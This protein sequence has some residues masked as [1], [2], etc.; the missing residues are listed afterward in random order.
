MATGD[1]GDS[2]V[3][4]YTQPNSFL[5]ICDG[6]QLGKTYEDIIFFTNNF[7]SLTFDWHR[8]ITA[9]QNFVCYQHRHAGDV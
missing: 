2:A 5:K 3:S 9:R 8:K 4:E 1:G 7:D 6:A